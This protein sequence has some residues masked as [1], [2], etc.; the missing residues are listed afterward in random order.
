MMK[1]STPKLKTAKSKTKTKPQDADDPLVEPELNPYQIDGSEETVH[2][3][4]TVS[5]LAL[6]GLNL[7]D[8]KANPNRPVYPATR[9]E[10]LVPFGT[11]SGNST[12]NTMRTALSRVLLKKKGRAHLSPAQVC[13]ALT[14]ESRWPTNWSLQALSV[15]K[16]IVEYHHR[17]RGDWP[18]W[19]RP[20]KL[21]RSFVD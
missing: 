16:R 13:K 3:V 12:N 1:K 15:V 21:D 11:L 7:A 20:D 4:R 2:W 19:L 6:R 5:F 8:H 10:K 18:N 9:L 17:D 14:A